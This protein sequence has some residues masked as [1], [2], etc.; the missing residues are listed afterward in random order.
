MT[1]TATVTPIRTDVETDD[2][3]IDLRARI[4]ALVD[5][6]KR[7]TQTRI[8]KEAGL[9]STVVSQWLAGQ[10]PGDIP[11]IEAKLLRWVD[12][13]AAQRARAE[14]LPEAPGFVSTP[15]AEKAIA[16]LRYAQIAG[17]IAIVYGGAGLGKTTAIVRYA[18]SSNNVWHAT[19]TPASSSVGTALEE[20]ADA[21][22]VG[23]MHGSSAAKLHRAICKRI[24]NTNGLLVIDEAQHLSV[25][26][27]DQ[28][29]SIHDATGIGIA[30]VGNESVYARM[31]GGNRAA[32]LDR[33]YSRIGKRVRLTK[34]SS[35]DITAL[36]GAWKIA[37]DECRAQLIEIASKPGALRI[38]TKVLRLGSM[39]AAA[40]KRALCCDDVRA[41]W[42]ELGGEA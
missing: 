6:D 28:I 39:Y 11:A 32:Y 26:A 30:L 42:R 4:R 8:A 37:H 7:L 20:I 2:S 33:L 36:L 31:T 14:S 3:G 17:D 16:A 13:H 35:A 12:S 19:M 34:S 15:S 21:V 25:A 24:A 1:A 40:Q 10:Y 29:R 5:Q 22:T 41:A 23:S 9:S 27:L 18:Q 38:L